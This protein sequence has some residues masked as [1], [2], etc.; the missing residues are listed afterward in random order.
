MH[1]AGD[2]ITIPNLA[3]VSIFFDD[4]QRQTRCLVQPLNCI[5]EGWT[6]AHTCAIRFQRHKSWNRETGL[7]TLSRPVGSRV[8]GGG[9]TKR[10]GAVKQ[11]QETQ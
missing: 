8:R 5:F 6:Y 9:N 2:A 1:P 7:A 3:P 10:W 11:D 4:F